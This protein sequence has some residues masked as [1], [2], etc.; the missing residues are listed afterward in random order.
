MANTLSA[1]TPEYW[2]KRVQVLL[3]KTLV[4]SQIASFEERSNLRNGDTIHRPRYSDVT[5]ASYTKGTAFTVQ[6]VTATDETL[7]VN[8]SKVVPVFVDRDDE[9][10]NKYSAANEYTRRMSYAL[11]EDIDSA[12]FREVANANLT[13]DDGDLGGTAGVPATLTAA[14]ALNVFSTAYAKLSSNNVESDRAWALVLDPIH[15]SQIQQSSI[16][17]GFNVSDSMLRNGFVSADYLGFKVLMSNNLRSSGSLG[18]AT[19]PTANDTVTIQGV[20]FTF[21]ATPA[22][23]GDVD[24]GASAAVSVANLTAAV[25]GGA[26]AGTT[27]IEVSS[28]NRTT[29]TN[30]HV[31][32]VDNT[33][34][35]GL[36][37]SGRMTLLETLT[38][39]GDVFA[40]Q[41]VNAV[42]MRT[43]AIDL[44]TQI[45]PEI[46]VSDAQPR[47]LIGKDFVGHT[48]YGL[49]TFTEGAERMVSIDIAV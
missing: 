5:V 41:A 37:A 40:T 13:L 4:S 15:I 27:Y 30:K 42:A 35:M 46:N 16:A 19:N 39:A 34:A 3:S 28:A 45:S 2:S 17:N 9:V 44:V 21:V 31:V 14:T 8:Q 12:F 49:R 32:A 48:L 6:D 23:A 47:G 20:T 38:A 36:T 18:I 7:V 22:A 24:I 25:N 29:L 33:T 10:Q 43:G 11:A 26:G 1:F